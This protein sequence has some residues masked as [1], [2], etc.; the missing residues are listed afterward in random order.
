MTETTIFHTAIIGGGASGLFCAGS[1]NNRKIVLE[2]NS[3]PAIKVS[4]SGGGKCN[5][6]N[7]MV[8]AKDYV[9]Q[10][11]HFCKNALA[12]FSYTDFTQLLDENNIA[13]EERENGK[14]F[15]YDAKKICKFLIERAKKNNTTI[16]CDTRVLDVVEEKGLYKLI[17]SKGI[18]LAQH[19]VF[20]T[21]GLSF[22][23]LGANGFG[24]KMANKWGI[25]TV[26]TAPALCGLNWPKELRLRFGGL[27]GNSLAVKVT[28]QKQQFQDALLFAHD[29]VTGPSIL[30]TSLFWPEGTPIT[31]NFA[32]SIELAEFISANKNSTKTITNFL[33]NYIPV[34][35][36]KVLLNGL[37][38]KLADMTKEQIKQVV[39]CI[40]AF[41]FVPSGTFGYTK[42]EATKGGIST[43]EINPTTF[44]LRK[45]PNAYA[46]G[47]VIDV[48]GRLGGFN[49]HWAWCSG[50]AAAK[51]LEKT[52]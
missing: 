47:E 51:H 1:F 10:G 28:C 16:S 39:E 32:P 35:I 36:A 44:Q 15:A 21:G 9:S 29:G 37:D 12:G 22:P 20:S 4:V 48:T 8:S 43:T 40:H 17:T 38:V 46:V 45:Y 19:I 27:A 11:K 42:A 49:L 30:Q 24:L 3:Q 18:F 23:S 7:K 34:K 6:T 33:G 50:F 14:L 13:W 25:K 5:F 26:E 31:I 2:A 52:F 41:T